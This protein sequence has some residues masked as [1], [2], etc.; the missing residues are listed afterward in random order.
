MKHLI[1]GVLAGAVLCSGTSFA[2][3]TA[4]AQGKKILVVYYSKTGTTERVSRDVASALNADLER[5]VDRKN[6]NGFFAFFSSG[7]DAM[8]KK[9]TSIE[10]LPRDPASYDLV[11][12]GTPVWAGNITP[13]I[14][15]FLMMNKDKLPDVAYIIT[16]A[17]TPAEKII[18]A[19]IDITGKKPVAYLGLV[20][21][22][23]KD[24]KV[25][26]WKLSSFIDALK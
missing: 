11:V 19:C 9:Q 12:V 4:V 15:T 18:P 5:V 20:K 3:E 7:K 8:G 17:H 1:L 25:Y 16:A 21:K 26:R 22:E 6:R 10:P 2:G 14:R 23:L 13:A 24:N